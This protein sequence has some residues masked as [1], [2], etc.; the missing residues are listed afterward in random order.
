M[1]II[2][3]RVG[4][5][6]CLAKC[7]IEVFKGNDSTLVIATEL[8]DNPGASIC[9]AFEDLILQVARAFD[10]DPARL[11]WIEHWAVW[12]ESEGAPYSRSGGE[13]GRAHV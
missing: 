8:P 5:N 4:F 11:L 1:N 12:Q 9:N 2:T 10:L 13:I 3:Y 7:G 6:D